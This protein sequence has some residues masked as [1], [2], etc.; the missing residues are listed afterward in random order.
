VS[1]DGAPL[2]APLA[3]TTELTGSAATPP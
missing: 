2:G 1:P 3:D